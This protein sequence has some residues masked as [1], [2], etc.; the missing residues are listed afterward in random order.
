VTAREQMLGTIRAALADV[1]A[2]EA[3]AWDPGVDGDRAAA[4][5]RSHPDDRPRLIE[6]FAE[7]CGA[8]SSRGDR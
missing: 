6:L 3:A 5:A 7:R 8:Y 1:S 2:G 4:Y